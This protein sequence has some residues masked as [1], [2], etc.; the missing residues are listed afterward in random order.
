MV[1]LL[2]NDVSQKIEVL[3]ISFYFGDVFIKHARLRRTLYGENIMELIVIGLLVVG[4]VVQHMLYV[5]LQEKYAEL[6][7]NFAVDLQNEV[8]KRTKGV[9]LKQLKD[10]VF[11]LKSHGHH[12]AVRCLTNL[13]M[14]KIQT[15]T[16]DDEWVYARD[17]R[18]A[19]ENI[20]VE[21]HAQS[22]ILMTQSERLKL[23]LEEF[24]HICKMLKDGGFKEALMHISNTEFKLYGLNS[25]L[26]SED[27]YGGYS[28]PMSKEHE[29]SRIICKE[30]Y[31]F[32]ES[33]SRA[34]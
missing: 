16:F 24:E 20:F 17:R 31:E 14:D 28:F 25:S 5:T 15:L 3:Y 8:K 1:F 4:L 29:L 33:L 7:A 9:A 34:A 10:I 23:K 6:K 12:D 2:K 30:K 11:D 26:V 18:H 19:I 32:A 22:H 27:M 13:E 21:E